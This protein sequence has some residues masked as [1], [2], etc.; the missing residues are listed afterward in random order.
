MPKKTIFIFSTA[1][2]PL[3]GGAEVA[4]KEITERITNY[5]FILLTAK[6]KRGLLKSEKIGN[7]QIH[8]LGF[9]FSF[10]KILLPFLAFF[11]YFSIIRNLKLEI[12]N[13]IFWGMMASY[14]SIG[15]YFIKI[16]KP[17]IP[18]LLTLQEGDSEEHLQKGK[19]GLVGFFGKRIIRK[20]DKIQAISNYL[21][22]FAFR[23]GARSPIHVVP[24]GVDLKKYK[25]QSIKHKNLKL[26]YN[27][28]DDEKIVITTS[29]LVYKNGID[30]LIKSIYE[31][32]KIDPGLKIKLLVL[33]DGG[34]RNE[35]ENLTEELNLKNETVFLGFVPQDEI[36]DYL[37]MADVFVRPSRSEGLGNSFLEAMATEVPVIGAAVGGIP[38]FLTDGETGLFC[39]TDNYKDLAEKIRLILEDSKLREKI[40]QNAKKLIQE[41]YDWEKIS[42]KMKEIFLL[43]K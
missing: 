8:R 20:A 43:M 30:I 24:N 27:I 26:E 34:L 14:G 19:F 41:K 12:R 29:R 15:A 21:K 4:V 7:I 2:L 11:K 23:Q 16:I 38:D 37:K 1:Y 33:G 32:K 31:L 18:F 3:V 17:E 39:E 9:G 13:S 40:I 25:T 35:L 28:K 6:M 10:D 22:D 36:Y 5:N 42:K